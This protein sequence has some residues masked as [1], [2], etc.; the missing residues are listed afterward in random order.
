MQVASFMDKYVEYWRRRQDERQRQ[1]RQLAKQARSDLEAVIAALVQEYDVKQIVLFGSLARGRF[2]HGSDVDLAVEGIP[3]REFFAAMA[4]AN[5]LTPL[6]IYLK[7]MEDLEPH[8]RERV[9]ET[10]EVMYEKNVER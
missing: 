6:W 7:P 5:R 2:A 4:L 8:F 9:F 10:G 1:N 3:P